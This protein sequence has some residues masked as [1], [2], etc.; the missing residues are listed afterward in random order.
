MNPSAT[1]KLIDASLNDWRSPI[2]AVFK[3]DYLA[4]EFSHNLAFIRLIN[5]IGN[6]AF[7][8]YTLADYLVVNDVASIS[9][10][11]RTLFFSCNLSIFHVHIRNSRHIRLLELHLP[12]S[13]FAA[14]LIWFEIL[15]RSQ[16]PLIAT[17]L[18]ASLVFIV[19]LN[20][21]IR[22]SYLSGLLTSLALSAL[23]IFQINR[24]N[25]GDLT[26]LFVYALVYVPVLLFSLFISWH[27]T[28]T[29]RKLF[30]HAQIEAMDKA[31]LKEANQR[32]WVQARTD[33][34]TGAANRESLEDRLQQCIA[35]ARRDHTHV[36]VLFIDLDK[37]KPV[38]DQ[39]GH[40]TGDQL[41]QQ[42]VQRLRQCVR[43]SDTVARIGGDEFVVLLSDVGTDQVALS[44]AEKIRVALSQPFHLA[45]TQVSIGSSIG[46]AL[47]PDHGAN[48]DS[49]IS[50]A[51]AALYQAKAQGRNCVVLAQ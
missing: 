26:A 22:V 30:L 50:A 4:H 14:A 37:F 10:A 47:F 40:G 31:E 24:L 46:V 19:L 17:Y 2:P 6:L 11:A 41:L 7:L 13:I 43:A 38:N 28:L 33:N 18:Y 27:I 48:M 29:G 25:Q 51:D 21:G 34:L 23:V 32:L 39:F 3:A 1:R 44:V 42:V 45:M 9:L 8:S 35:L 15:L 49:L 16:S 5:W 36:A 20:I 12:L